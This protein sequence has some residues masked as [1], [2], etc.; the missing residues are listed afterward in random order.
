M[1]DQPSYSSRVLDHLSLVASMFDELGIGD[2]TDQST[3]QHPNQP[4]SYL[5]QRHLMT[6][7][8]LSE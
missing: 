6:F 1:P 8:N 4:P 7:T 2:D 3:R 5:G